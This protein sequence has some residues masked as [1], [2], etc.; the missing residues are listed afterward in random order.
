MLKEDCLKNVV[1]FSFYLN[2]KM[3][4]QF[5]FLSSKLIPCKEKI[6]IELANSLDLR[7]PHQG[8]EG[9]LERAKFSGHI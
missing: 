3:P 7:E 5:L 4:G 2:K 9:I 6:W 1:D 8:S